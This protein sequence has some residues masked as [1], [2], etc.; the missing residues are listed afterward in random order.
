MADA[1]KTAKLEAI[2]DMLAETGKPGKV[3]EGF[4]LVLANKAK[5]N[6]N[7]AEVYADIKRQ[8]PKA[9]TNADFVLVRE[10][11]EAGVIA[12]MFANEMAD[13]TAEKT[14]AKAEAAGA[15]DTTGQAKP[16]APAAK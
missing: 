15:K 8:L 12:K 6:P 2:A 11:G 3:L 4:S 10:K 9:D 13:D 16:A 5:G 7:I 14:F 1:K